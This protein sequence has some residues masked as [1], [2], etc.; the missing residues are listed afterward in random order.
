MKRIGW[1]ILLSALC[2][3]GAWW[4]W[5][6][7]VR[8]P[9]P[10]PLTETIVRSDIVSAVQASGQLQPIR[11][12]DV[13]AQVSGQLKHLYVVAGQRVRKG[14]LLAEIDPRLARS[15]LQIALAELAVLQSEARGLSVRYHYAD[16]ELHR[17]QQLHA[18]GVSAERELQQAHS[19]RAQLAADLA[20]VR[21]RIRRA[22]LMVEQQRTRLAYTR[23]EAPMDGEVLAIETREGQ[24][25]IAAQQAPTILKLGDL[26]RLRVRANVS[27]ADILRIHPGQKAW[28]SLLGHPAQR[29]EG[30]VGEV[31]PTPQRINNALY[32]YVQFDVDN[33]Q[34]LR[35]EMTAQV[36]IVLAEARQVVAVPLMAL[37]DEAEEGNWHSVRVLG[38]DGSVRPQRVRIGLRGRTQAEVLEGLQPGEQVVI[39]D[40]RLPLQ[41]GR[42]G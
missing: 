40:A 27:E 42:H 34:Q 37:D 33:P 12:V 9:A 6:R 8:S 31:L 26:S 39:S 2:S 16:R 36:S 21:A 1:I 14:Q 29:Y 3:S 20:G 35:T 13:G 17:Q 7:T 38:K 25:V 23:I 24:T 11:T 28:F 22:G 41:E 32:F 30:R 5:H 4:L 18:G 15:E 19:Q 10:A